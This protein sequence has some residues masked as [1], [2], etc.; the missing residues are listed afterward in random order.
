MSPD[1][2]TDLDDWDELRQRRHGF[3]FYF[4]WWLGIFFK[5]LG[6]GVCDNVL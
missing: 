1:E 6:L 3:R 4:P 5:L 2:N